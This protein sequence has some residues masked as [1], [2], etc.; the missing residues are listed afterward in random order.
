VAV[1]YHKS[2][3]SRPPFSLLR[4]SF[5]PFPLVLS[6]GSRQSLFTCCRTFWC[7]LY[8]QTAL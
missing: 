5:L 2:W 6:R 3:G 7:N 4:S 1:I 8:S